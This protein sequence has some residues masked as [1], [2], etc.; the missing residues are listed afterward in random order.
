MP[1]CPGGELA[2]CLGEKSG[3]VEPVGRV[4]HWGPVPAGEQNTKRSN[5]IYMSDNKKKHLM[6]AVMAGLLLGGA[7]AAQ[8]AQTSQADH[9]LGN[10]DKPISIAMEKAACNG[11]A[12]CKSTAS[13]KATADAKDLHACK[14][15]NACKGK[16]GCK[17]DDNSCAGK[18][19][20]KGKGGCAT[21]KHDC[22]G[23]NGCKAQGGCEGGDNGCA[24]KN[25]C[26]GKG[27]CASPVK[28]K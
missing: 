17:S 1:I 11:K 16:G 27:G 12:G 20:C 22:K 2:A 8:A 13:C 21:A 26:K 3:A 5:R 9:S 14:G 18:N 19:E 15:M 7:Q 25:S 24:G 28:S 6:S 4:S 23:K 10:G